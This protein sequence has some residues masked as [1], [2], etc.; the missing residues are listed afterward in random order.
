MPI[1]NN[2][3]K[4]LYNLNYH[5]SEDIKYFPRI[6]DQYLPSLYTHVGSTCDRYGSVVAI[7]PDGNTIAVGS[8]Y[9]SDT[10]DEGTLF[11]TRLCG[12][13]K[14]YKFDG[15]NWYLKGEP[16]VG[17][18]KDYMLGISI[19]MNNDGTKIIIGSAA[20]EYG[21]S[22]CLD[23]FSTPDVESNTTAIYNDSKEIYDGVKAG[24]ENSL[25]LTDIAVATTGTGAV[26]AGAAAGVTLIANM[27]TDALID[28]RLDKEP[29]VLL[30]I[31]QNSYFEDGISPEGNGYPDINIKGRGN[32]RIYEWINGEWYNTLSFDGSEYD[33]PENFGSSVAMDSIGETIA[34]GSPRFS[35]AERYRERKDV[36]DWVIFLKILQTV[37][38][39]ILTVAGG[40]A[41]MIIAGIEMTID[42]VMNAIEDASKVSDR[43]LQ[44]EKDIAHSVEYFREKDKEW[45]DPAPYRT[46][47][48]I[49]RDMGQILFYDIKDRKNYKLKTT[50]TENYFK[51]PTLLNISPTKAWII[52]EEKIQANIKKGNKLIG[53]R[54]GGSYYGEVIAMNKVGNK[55]VTFNKNDHSINTQVNLSYFADP[56]F[57]S[58]DYDLSKVLLTMSGDGNKLAVGLPNH[59]ITWQKVGVVLIF[60]WHEVDRGWRRSSTN[61]DASGGGV[62]LR[63]NNGGDKFGNS[64]SLNYDG[65][66]LAV[67]SPFSKGPTEGDTNAGRVTVYKWNDGLESWGY[68]GSLI[69]GAKDNLLG[70]S[71]KLS[72]LGD[73]IV[74][75][76]PCKHI[77]SEHFTFKP[78]I[79]KEMT[80]TH[81]FTEEY[82]IN[83]T[84]FEKDVEDYVFGQGRISGSNTTTD[85]FV[86]ISNDS[87]DY[88]DNEMPMDNITDDSVGINPVIYGDPVD[89]K[90]GTSYVDYLSKY[91][92]SYT[93]TV[94]N[95][96]YSINTES[97]DINIPNYDTDT[98][99]WMIYKTVIKKRRAVS[100]YEEGKY[101]FVK[102]F[103]FINGDWNQNCKDSTESTDLTLVPFIPELPVN[104]T[105]MNGMKIFNL[106]VDAEY[107]DPGI[108][109]PSGHI[110]YKTISDIN[111]K[112][113]GYYNNAYLIKNKRGHVSRFD[114]EVNI[115][116]RPSIN[117]TSPVIILKG[118]TFN[119][120]VNYGVSMDG[121]VDELIATTH[122]VDTAIV[123]DY[124]IIYSV[125]IA[126]YIY[127][128]E[129]IALKRDVKVIPKKIITINGGTQMVRQFNKYK[130]LGA[131]IKDTDNN[132]LS[133]KLITTSITFS[134]DELGTYYV[135]YSAEYTTSVTRRVIVT[136]PYKKTMQSLMYELIS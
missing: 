85:S 47:H 110:L 9:Y 89:N 132:I 56:I 116:R 77:N 60:V 133:P 113:A 38:N 76:A 46:Q 52:K 83:G 41:G 95:L 5:N 122:D 109:I 66:I 63:G 105:Q 127:K 121:H 103:K 28:G 75:G 74:I 125:A 112:V 98:I 118:D 64:I 96:R 94:K 37:G 7:S 84:K 2:N 92:N 4:N 82:S 129:V 10:S 135:T 134:T 1:I 126:K 71:L 51:K 81:K 102:V 33:I 54:M 72:H 107:V 65:T 108:T 27:T 13:V 131:T 25:T 124:S 17:P 123:G 59:S 26:K 34:I 36:E 69:Q 100:L 31:Q 79:Y 115:I 62:L 40:G 23:Y 21:P 93:K 11:R 99:E 55:I 104:F 101:G 120:N 20:I 119:E 80:R 88:T 48:T 24:L 45:M 117:N 18:R 44:R 114:R 87:N 8:P 15:N 19:D 35:I 6:Y 58:H 22:R 106:Y 97:N 50:K 67:G 12:M 32:V 3:N 14:I 43:F 73:T 57:I 39:H 29:D 91:Y 86:E 136:S 61:D 90:T 128:S 49:Y 16:I 130:D 111:T 70:T 53:D 78:T 68:H 30:S 42:A